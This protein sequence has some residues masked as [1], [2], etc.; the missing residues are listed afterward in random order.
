MKKIVVVGYGPA[1]H[2]LV[3]ALLQRGFDGRITV[4]GEEPR[5]AYDRVALTSYLSG[6]SA[7]DLSYPVP[8]AGGGHGSAAASPASTGRPAWSPSK[9]ARGSRT[10]CW[11]WPP[12]PAPFVPPVPGA[13]HAYVYRTIDDLDAIRLAAKE[14]AD[15]RRRRRRAA[16]PGGGRRAA[17]ARTA[18]PHRRDGRRG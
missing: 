10:T 4:I 14:A 8:G 5:P 11:C 2:R 6:V 9:A 3:E 16:R 17:L 7:E 1:A 13:E 15:R 18:H 12:G